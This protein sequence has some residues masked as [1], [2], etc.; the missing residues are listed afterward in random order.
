MMPHSRGG[1]K[2]VYEIDG[3]DFATLEEFFDAVSRVLIPGA[4]WGHNLDAFDSVSS[5]CESELVRQ[6]PPT[7]RRDYPAVRQIPLRLENSN[8]VEGRCRTR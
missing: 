5:W 6:V 3:C 1:A 4:E 2:S 7:Q 8:V